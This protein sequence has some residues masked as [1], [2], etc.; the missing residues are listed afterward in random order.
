MT[1]GWR[2][3]PAGRPAPS[4]DPAWPTAPPRAR[5]SPWPGFVLALAITLAWSIGWGVFVDHRTHPYID[6]RVP[7]G[8]GWT[9]RHGTTF[10]VLGA[11][12]RTMISRGYG[13][14]KRPPEGA[15][16]VVVRLKYENWHEGSACS[17]LSLF[18][19]GLLRW[20]DGSSLPG[21]NDDEREKYT[22]CD[23]DENP[24]TGTF[25]LTFVVPRSFL[26]RVVGVADYY[27]QMRHDPVLEVPKLT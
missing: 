26:D 25:A 4:V 17:G 7:F 8:Q 12:T 18:G 6:G 9:D 21:A 3:A 11:E 16:Y 13:D 19:E 14:D 5:R 24:H 20:L 1:G 22:Y 15:V 10:T 2:S 23:T 27:M